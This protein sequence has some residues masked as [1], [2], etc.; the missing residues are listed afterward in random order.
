VPLILTLLVALIGSVFLT[1][2]TWGRRIFAV[3]GNI[4]AARYSGLK[5]RPILTGVYT[6]AGLTAGL[7]GFL[8]CSYY[9]SA[10]SAD[11]Q[12]YELYVIAAAVVGGASLI[13]GKGS[14]SGAILGALLIALI[15]QA[16]RTLN[17]NTNYEWI[18]IGV[19]II[20]AVVLDRTSARLAE[21]RTLRQ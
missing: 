15:R 6:I 16:I 20:V 10:S 18:I 11:A 21:Q 1:R 7:A 19:A 2:T 14:A 13:G 4:E 12:G 8:G 17:F 9:G 3:G 5:I